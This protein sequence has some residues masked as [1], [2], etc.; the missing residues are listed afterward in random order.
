MTK[1][2]ILTILRAWHNAMRECDERMDQLAAVAGQVVESPLGDAVY[3]VMGSYTRATADLIDWDN[4]TLE[5]WWTEHQFGEK[6]M[7]IGFHDDM[8]EISTIEALAEFIVDDLARS[9]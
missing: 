2:R 3:H 8:R 9:V 1:D 7:S 4:E 5:A 6:P